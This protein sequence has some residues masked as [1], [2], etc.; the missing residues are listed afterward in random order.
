MC[1]YILKRLVNSIR[2]DYVVSSIPVISVV[3]ILVLL[4]LNSYHSQERYR[5]V[6]YVTLPDL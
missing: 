4:L 1:S 6:Q 3:L 5:Y 2:E